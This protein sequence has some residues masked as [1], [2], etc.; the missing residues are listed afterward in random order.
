MTSRVDVE[1]LETTKSEKLLAVVLGVFL[2]IGSLWAYDKLYDL[3]RAIIDPADFPFFTQDKELREE[4]NRQWDRVDWLAFAFRLPLALSLTTF[5][6]WLLARLRRTASQYLPV[7]FAFVGSAVILDLVMAGDYVSAWVDPLE[8]G[9]LV[10]SLFGSGAT[11]VAFYGLQRYLARR[12][13]YRRVRKSEC[14]FCSYPT[15]SAEFCEGCGRAVIAPCTR[16]DSPR[17][18]GTVHCG[19]CG[20][21]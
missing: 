7:G 5:S 6:L 4:I 10:L 16:C 11:L 1:E 13:P 9:P 14:P 20:A 19:A 8:F 17:R 2:L 12:L 3:A 15:R 18:V 21:T